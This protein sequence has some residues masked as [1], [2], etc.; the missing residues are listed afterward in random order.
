[1]WVRHA[2]CVYSI[3]YE[4]SSIRVL[5]HTFGPSSRWLG[6]WSYSH[7][8]SWNYWSYYNVHCCQNCVIQVTFDC[9]SIIV[10]RA[11]SFLINTFSY[12]LVLTCTANIS[13]KNILL[14]IGPRLQ[15]FVSHDTHIGT[16]SKNRINSNPV[17]LTQLF[18]L[19]V[20][21]LSGNHFYKHL[22]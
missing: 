3:P 5:D 13:L 9:Q 20:L 10:N 4:N 21:L 2:R 12:D 7:L 14:T 18:F 22:N 8:K 1:M 16:I 17:Q 11:P 6:D 19:L 15:S